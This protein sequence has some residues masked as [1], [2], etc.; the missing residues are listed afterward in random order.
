MLD[1]KKDVPQ[2]RVL[3]VNQLKQA[4]AK[5]NQKRIGATDRIKPI[6]AKVI[7]KKE[8]PKAPGLADK[9]LDLSRTQK[10][11]AHLGRKSKRVEKITVGQALNISEQVQEESQ[12]SPEPEL[13]GRTLSSSLSAAAKRSAAAP[14]RQQA[15][16]DHEH[17]TETAAVRE[18]TSNDSS[19][20]AVDSFRVEVAPLQS[21]FLNADQIFV[22]RRIMINNQ[23]YRQGFILRTKAFLDH[24]AATYFI[25]QPMARYTKLY[26]KVSDQGLIRVTIQA[27]VD[28][29]G[30]NFVFNRNFPAPFSFLSARLICDQIPQSAG[31]RILNVMIIILVLV[32]LMG[33]IAIYQSAGALVDLAERRAQFVSSVT[34][35]LKTPLTNIRMYIEMLEQGIA[36]DEK[37]EQEYFQILDSEGAR[38]SRLINNVLELSKLEKKQRA[39]DLQTGTFKEVILEVQ[40]V[41]Q[42][43]LVHEGYRLEVEFG[44]IPP[45]K[46]DR[47]V[48]IQVLINLIENSMKF[49]KNAPLK[50]IDLRVYL[51]ANWVTI[52]VRDRGPGIPRR[53]LK[54]IFDEFYRVDN[55]LAR[56]TRGT[57]IGLALVKK[58][59]GLMGGKVTAANNDGPGCT[60]TISL[61]T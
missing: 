38:L 26:L 33:L 32:V 41:M 16:M 57:G 9:Y 4:N 30:T 60:I 55:A 45:F 18:P 10:P 14:L 27:G 56:T 22:F 42:A 20:R 13:K 31:R 37:R 3:L 51:E 34:H 17:S 6:P 35:E 39:V 54:K 47:E 15:G 36:R 21:V 48:M 2:N 11:K 46:Y 52:M 49:G 28:A 53:A 61:P 24:L 19:L 40:R 25:A 44:T 7:A 12:P 29:Q 50:R 43:K 59:V 5:F 1:G 8:A 23:I 58:F